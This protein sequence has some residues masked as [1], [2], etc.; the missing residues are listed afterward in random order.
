M[1]VGGKKAVRRPRDP[2]RMKKKRVLEKGS[3]LGGET[4]TKKRVG[5]S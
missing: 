5:G 4:H 1:G 2:D 3:G